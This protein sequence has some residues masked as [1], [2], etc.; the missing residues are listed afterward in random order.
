MTQ[1]LAPVRKDTKFLV[2]VCVFFF[3]SSDL[4]FHG[5]CALF[6][7]LLWLRPSSLGLDQ[8]WPNLSVGS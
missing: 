2:C 7:F 4:D 5:R 1:G 6:D 3:N 8:G